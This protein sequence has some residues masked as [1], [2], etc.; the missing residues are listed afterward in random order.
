MTLICIIQLD[1]T[2]TFVK[3]CTFSDK[4]VLHV[5]WQ[6]HRH[7]SPKTSLTLARPYGFSSQNLA[8]DKE[9][10][11]NSFSKMKLFLLFAT[12]LGASLGFT[13]NL[14]FHPHLLNKPWIQPS[15]PFK[16]SIIDLIDE[17][18]FAEHDTKADKAYIRMKKMICPYCP[19][20]PSK[21]SVPDKLRILKFK[22][23]S[24][25]VN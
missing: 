10:S 20:T 13:G 6:S 21:N 16:A 23:E 8:F 17:L 19:I 3:T 7:T 12:L 24:S 5:D 1:F 2:V 25:K 14:G 11:W 4:I 22:T 18:F 9:G 15:K